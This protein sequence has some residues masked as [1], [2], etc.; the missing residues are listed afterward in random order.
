MNYKR[1]LIT[2]G[3]GSIGNSL[4]PLLSSIY[5]E[6]DIGITSSLKKEKINYIN[7]ERPIISKNYL[8][9]IFE[10]SPSEILL[11][12]SNFHPRSSQGNLDKVII[13]LQIPTLYLIKELLKQKTLKK[14]IFISS[15]NALK[16]LKMKDFFSFDGLINPYGYEKLSSELIL[17]NLCIENNVS[18]FSLR[19][20]NI[21]NP[22]SDKKD[23]GV[24][25]KF[26]SLV[27]NGERPEFYED[28]YEEKDYIHVTDVAEAILETL[29]INSGK[30]YSNI[31]IASGLSSNARNIYESL[32]RLN[33][34]N[35]IIQPVKNNIDL[36]NTYA[37][38]KWKPKFNYRDI[39]NE[40]LK[41]KKNDK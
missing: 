24:V 9:R 19:P 27:I 5:K 32:K 17:R 36:K 38:L 26:A 10:F 35:D 14:V 4:L 28:S 8:K 13:D 31:T 41:A 1:I 30:K 40:C 22:Y 6:S 2:G 11:M 7:F 25:S 23:F 18:F 29:I 3:Y 16:S 33:S 34:G 15:Y 20:T 12:G 37:I 39:L 21:V